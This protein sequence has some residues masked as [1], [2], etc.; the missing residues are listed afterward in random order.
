MVETLALDD[1]ERARERAVDVLRAGQLVV[2][3]TD[4]VYGVAADAFQPVATRRLLGAKRR[5]RANPLG[6]VIRTPR[7]VNGLVAD[8]PECAERLMASYWPGP[9]TL[10]FRASDGMSWDLGNT[11]DTVA[12]RLTADDFVM[13]LVA[14]VGP[15]ACTAANRGRHPA[16]TTAAAAQEQLGESV[17]L[18]VDGGARAAPASTIVDVTRGGAEV[19][20]EGAIP[21]A[22]VEQV[23]TGKVGWGQRPQEEQP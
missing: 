2:V 15:L 14:E 4:T 22:A 21:A 13:S 16:P 20:R 12:L 9:L 1:V 19:L 6:V 10:V 18:Y 23:A 11:Q 5:N 8:V 17:A 3:P 7:Q